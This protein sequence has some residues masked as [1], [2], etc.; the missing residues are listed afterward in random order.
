MRFLADENID[1]RVVAILRAAGHDVLEVREGHGGSGDEA[2]LALARRT[3]RVLLTRD[4]D[5]GELVIR[6]DLRCAGLVLVRYR[7][8]DPPATAEAI[9]RVVGAEGGALRRSFVVVEKDRIRVLRLPR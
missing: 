2:V 1:Q 8:G 3:R 5:F 7:H 9:L 6:R 4:K